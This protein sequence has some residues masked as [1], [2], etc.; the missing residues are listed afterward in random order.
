MR[1][2]PAILAAMTLVVGALIVPVRAVADPIGDL[3]FLTE[4][5]AP[6]NYSK[7]GVPQGTSVE[8]LLKMFRAANSSKTID[9]IK[10]LP[11]ARGYQLAQQQENTVLFS[12]TRTEARESLFKWVGPITPTR[13]SIVAK[14]DRNIA[15]TSFADITAY[16]IGAVREDIGELLL[17]ENNVPDGSIHQ[18]NSSMIAAKMLAA[19][20]IDMWAYEESVAFWNLK[21]EGEDLDQY[22]VIFVLEE[23]ELYFAVQKDTR[24]ALVAALQSALD[25]ARGQPESI[26]Q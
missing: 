1:R 8:L 4:N 21:D 15:V 5:Y 22:E 17:K 7:D 12:T 6:F 2:F 19:D 9:D 3:V 14:K 26:N 25:S 10:V 24:D 23:S 20:R 18:I 11:W 16:E 13:V